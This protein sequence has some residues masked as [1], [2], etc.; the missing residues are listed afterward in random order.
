MQYG[1][2]NTFFS[3]S[4]LGKW[5]EVAKDYEYLLESLLCFSNWVSKMRT[6][7]RSAFT[8]LLVYRSIAKPLPR[9]SPLLK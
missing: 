5:G 1:K 9:R 2:K 4:V 3:G 6:D 7:F 8:Q